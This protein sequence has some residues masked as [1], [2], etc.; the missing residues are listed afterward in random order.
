[1]DSVEDAARFC[2]QYSEALEKKYPARTQLFRR[3][4][5][6]QFRAGSGGV[7]LRCSGT[8]CLTVE[9]ASRE[10]FDK[11]NSA[12]GWTS[13]PSPSSAEG[14]QSVAQLTGA[15]RQDR[16]ALPTAR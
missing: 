11:I 4:N 13:P 6:F 1:L 10:T 2:G 8:Q 14:S 3:P 15:R 9:G 7:F 12:I 16:A 5:F